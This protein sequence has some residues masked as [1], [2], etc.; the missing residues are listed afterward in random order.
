MKFK[1]NQVKV[2]SPV[3]IRERI[4]WYMRQDEPKAVEQKVRNAVIHAVLG[5]SIMAALG[6]YNGV[7]GKYDYSKKAKGESG[8]MRRLV[9]GWLV[10]S[11]DAIL[12]PI[13]S[14]DH[15]LITPQAING[16]SRWVSELDNGVYKQRAAFSTELLG[17]IH[18]AQTDYKLTEHAITKGVDLL[19]GDC[20]EH[21]R[22]NSAVYGGDQE[23]VSMHFNIPDFTENYVQERGPEL[24]AQHEK[25]YTQTAGDDDLEGY[26]G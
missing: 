8:H 17:V 15:G 11:D 7:T 14:K 20:V 13:S 6:F 9:L 16:I 26:F 19:L 5:K 3:V 10:L 1:T 2:H 23:L 21:W 22:Q 4:Q 25:A 18:Y 24:L 12:V